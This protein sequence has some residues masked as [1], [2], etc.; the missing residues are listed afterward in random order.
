MTSLLRRKAAIIATAFMTAVSSGAIAKIEP[1]APEDKFSPHWSDT[2]TTITCTSDKKYT[3][4]ADWTAYQSITDWDRL[5]GDT[6]A[7]N[8]AFQQSFDAAAGPIFAKMWNDL[9]RQGYTPDHIAQ[10]DPDFGKAISAA[11][12]DAAQSI[13][14]ATG[15]TIGIDG[16]IYEAV[17]GCTLK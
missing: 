1:D 5:N 11:M 9:F 6:E 7:Q 8:Q 17:P 2:Y 16:T 13:E 10:Q 3:L 12:E 4:T 15:V 14:A